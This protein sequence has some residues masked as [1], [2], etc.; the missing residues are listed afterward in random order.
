MNFLT[1]GKANNNLNSIAEPELTL[2]VGI[3]YILEHKNC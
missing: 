3:V 1:L 2:G